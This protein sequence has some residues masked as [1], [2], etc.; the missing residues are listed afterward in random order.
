MALRGQRTT[1]ER[2]VLIIALRR[3]GKTIGYLANKFSRSKE[4]IRQ[5]TKKQ[6][7]LEQQPAMER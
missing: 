2:D 3:E 6:E 7:R 4:R 5:I 1:A